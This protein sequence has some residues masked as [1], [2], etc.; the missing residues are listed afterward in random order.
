[1]KITAYNTTGVRKEGYTVVKVEEME[2]EENQ[3]DKPVKEK[4]PPST[5]TKQMYD[6][7]NIDSEV[8]IY[9]CK[10]VPETELNK[11][12]RTHEKK[13][14]H[15]LNHQENQKKHKV[16]SPV[17]N[18]LSENKGDEGIT[19]PDKKSDQRQKT[20]P[21]A[22]KNKK[23]QP[24]TTKQ[25]T[26]KPQIPVNEPTNKEQVPSKNDEA[27]KRK[28]T[29]NKTIQKDLNGGKEKKTNPK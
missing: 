28:S 17:A 19:R 22:Y 26:N 21:T 18:K 1:M 6:D 4:T 13:G 14:L 2:C 8:G 15:T 24:A 16:N 29:S 12:K 25:N 11:G 7:S 9:N 3:G 27:I 23:P 5:S 10:Y 20:V